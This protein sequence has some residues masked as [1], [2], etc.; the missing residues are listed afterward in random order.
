M[1]SSPSSSLRFIILSKSS[2]DIILISH[3]KKLESEI[4]MQSSYFLSKGQNFTVLSLFFF[5]FQRG[6][7]MYSNLIV[8]TREHLIN[9]FLVLNRCKHADNRYQNKTQYHSQ[10][11][12]IYR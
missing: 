2:L 7:C 11:T 4:R 5:V 10:D 8:V 1:A 3:P 6:Q 9:I 12:C